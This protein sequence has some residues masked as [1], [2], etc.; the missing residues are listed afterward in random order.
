MGALAERIDAPV[1]YLQ[2]DAHLDTADAIDG[3]RMTMASPVA[4]IVE[5]PNVAARNVAVVA[6]RGVANSFEEIE[7][8][9]AL[10]IHV[11]PMLDILD[12][13]AIA[14]IEDALDAVWD[15]VDTVYVSFDN[16]AVDASAAPGTTAP[17]PFGLDA[18]DVVGM[19]MRIGRRGV[20]L[21]DV[22]ELSPGY[23]PSGITA[24][25]DCYWLIYLLAAYARG[26]ESG[27][28]APPPYAQWSA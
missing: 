11:F 22:V 2:I 12:R 25:L 20:G 14:V 13:G 16:D 7:N 3:E 6:A 15:G 18:R 21:L 10:G 28:A 19:A 23:D 5:Y 26:T 27:S 17:E 24:R 4:R 1:G 9:R 8:A